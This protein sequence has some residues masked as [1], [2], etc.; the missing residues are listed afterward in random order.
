[1]QSFS[2]SL[3][4]ILLRAAHTRLCVLVAPLYSHQ[5]SFL[6]QPADE[7]TESGLYGVHHQHHKNDYVT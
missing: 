3:L 4:C 5:I 6:L 1:M 2:T 7:V